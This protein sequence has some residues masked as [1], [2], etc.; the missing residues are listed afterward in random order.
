M[1]DRCFLEATIVDRD[2]PGEMIGQPYVPSANFA[3]LFRGIIHLP[4]L[5]GNPERVYPVAAV[6]RFFEGTFDRYVASVISEWVTEKDTESLAR[7]ADDLRLLGL[8]RRVT[9]VRLNDAN[10]ELRVG[11]MPVAA[12][13]GA[14]DLVNIADVGFGVAQTLPVV[15]ALIVAGKDDMVYI[16]EPESHLHPRAQ[17]A[18]AQILANAAK[19]GVR[20]VVETHSSLLLI[21]IQALV[22]EGKLAPDKV[23]LHW[24]TRD[25]KD[26]AT[27]IRSADMDDAGA[28]ENWPEDF[29]TTELEAQRR[30][31]DAADARLAGKP[32]G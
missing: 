10:V 32:H 31:L 30:Y 17:V 27:T 29:G 8:T 16:E 19:R 6:G 2:H 18:M 4:A 22:A 26:G 20:V 1:P 24:F 13:N 11:R 5:R 9:A 3:Q 25:P 28:C 23:K 21:S 12:G 14:N 7:L 15:T